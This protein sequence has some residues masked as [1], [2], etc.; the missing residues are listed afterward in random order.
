MNKQAVDRITNILKNSK[1]FF[2][3]TTDGKRPYVRPYN[4]VVQFEDKVYFYTNNRTHAFKQIE[5]NSFVEMCAMI[6]EGYDRW[7]RVS[8]KVEYDYRPEV[9]KAMLDANP[10]LRSMYTEDDKIFYVFYL[11]NMSAT[12]HSTHSET[13]VIC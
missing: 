8:G 5:T 13:E 11:S 6:G 3:A 12:I 10:E 7:L 9:K 1:N 2:F 4:A